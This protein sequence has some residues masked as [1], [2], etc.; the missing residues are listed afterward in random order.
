MIRH[1]QTVG[2]VKHLLLVVGGRITGRRCQA[3]S[4]E[5]VLCA[6]VEV[7]ER[8]H[9]RVP[10]HVTICVVHVDGPVGKAVKLGVC[11]NAAVGQHKH[12]DVQLIF[13]D[14]AIQRCTYQFL[15]HG[16]QIDHNFQLQVLPEGHAGLLDNCRTWTIKNHSQLVTNRLQRNRGDD[17][18]G[19][20]KPHQECCL[21][22]LLREV[23]TWKHFAEV[24]ANHAGQHQNSRVGLQKILAPHEV[25]PRQPLVVKEFIP[26]AFVVR[27]IISTSGK[28]TSCIASCVRGR[29][30]VPATHAAS[31]GRLPLE[32]AS[33][34]VN[35]VGQQEAAPQNQKRR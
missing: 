33:C 20:E 11:N 14:L 8:G 31:H 6:P 16:L 34:N 2:M 19:P 5:P 9:Q 15:G 7:E 4:E 35:G 27:W 28:S 26:T 30:L 32:R 29:L 23:R 1:A 18:A 22:L 13:Q 12:Q 24:E 17:E 25:H 3:V 10:L 21:H